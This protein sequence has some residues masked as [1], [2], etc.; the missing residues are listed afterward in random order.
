MCYTSRGKT[1]VLAVTGTM[2]SKPV[3]GNCVK[4]N[5]FA[6]LMLAFAAYQIWDIISA[7]W[8][9]GLSHDRLRNGRGRGKENE[10]SG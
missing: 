3:V 4:Q 9:S 5:F 7:S 2:Y 6:Y 1:Q 10:R 8:S